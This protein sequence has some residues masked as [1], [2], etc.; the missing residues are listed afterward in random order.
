MKVYRYMSSKEF[1]MLTAGMTISG[2]KYHACRTTS[3]GVCFLAENT[4]FWS[5][6]L[7][8]EITFSP[9]AC[10]DFLAGIVSSDVLVEFRTECEVT[11]SIGVYAD[12]FGCFYDR[13]VIPEFCVASYSMDTFVPVRYTT[14]GGQWYSI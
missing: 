2:K 1:Q 4:T 14:G 12:P 5:D 10:Y 3:T 13:I 6:T 11:E 8:E 9:E 7:H